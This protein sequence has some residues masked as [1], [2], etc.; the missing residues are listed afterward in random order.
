[1]KIHPKESTI[2]TTG[3]DKTIK[4]SSLITNNTIFSYGLEHPSLACCWNLDDDKYFYCS[5]QNFVLQ[6]DTRKTNTYF[7]K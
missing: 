6:F 5:Q 7:C 1:M 4:L 2:L 3:M